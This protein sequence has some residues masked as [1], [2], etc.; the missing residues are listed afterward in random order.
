S[1][2]DISSGRARRGAT[3]SWACQGRLHQ[4]KPHFSAQHLGGAL[5][6]EQSHVAVLWIEQAAYLAAA[7][8]HEFGETRLRELLALH[9]VLDLPG[10]NLFDCHRL[11]LVANAF[12]FK[13]SVKR[14][15]V[16]GAPLL[17]RR[18]D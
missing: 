7:G 2:W 18:H 17:F 8:S 6:G 11:K 5:Q 1:S 3:P 13:E 9:G 12:R 15:E 16:R 4:F 10:E 14:G